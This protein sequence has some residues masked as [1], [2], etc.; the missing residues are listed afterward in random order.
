MQ[1]S[2]ETFQAL[3]ESAPLGIVI[4][5]RDGHIVRVNAKVQAMFGYDPGEAEE[6]LHL[7]AQQGAPSD[8]IAHTARCKQMVA[9]DIDV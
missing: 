3:L 5:D 6:T 9:A 1:E 4:V 2:D 7:A 8:V